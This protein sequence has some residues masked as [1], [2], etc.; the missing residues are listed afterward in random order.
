MSIERY[1]IFGTS[2]L[3]FIRTISVLKWPDMVW[4]LETWS[5]FWII[6]CAALA[7]WQRWP[8]P[9]AQQFGRLCSSAAVVAA[10]GPFVEGKAAAVPRDAAN[11]AQTG[12]GCGEG[13]G[14]D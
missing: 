14:V 9:A 2:L 1:S 12:S 13:S 8:L 5:G 11:A 10:R 3:W 7:L 6:P 4:F